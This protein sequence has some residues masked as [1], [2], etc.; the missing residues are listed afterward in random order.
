[1]T[2]FVLRYY[3]LLLIFLLASPDKIIAQSPSAEV[4]KSLFPYPEQGIWLLHFTGFNQYGEP[5]QLSLAHDQKNVH[6]LLQNFNTHQ[7]WKIEGLWQMSAMNTIVAD[8]S[9][10]RLGQMK[11]FLRDS[12]LTADIIMDHDQMASSFKLKQTAMYSN[13]FPPC[14]LSIV[15][16]EYKTVSGKISLGMRVYEDGAIT[17][18][19]SNLM[20]STASWF[21]GTC[22]SAECKSALVIFRDCNSVKKYK[23]KMI[24]SD[25]NRV[26]LQ[27]ISGGKFGDVILSL[28]RVLHFNC[29]NEIQMGLQSTS[30]YPLIEERNF[31]KWLVEYNRKWNEQIYLYALK[32]LLIN[33]TFTL[34]W[35][36]SWYSDQIL[37]GSIIKYEPGSMTPIEESWNYDIKADEVFN[38]EDL[39]EK[40]SN[41]RSFLDHYLYEVKVNM[42][43][44]LQKELYEFI[45]SDPFRNYNLLPVGIVFSTG[46]NPVFG[47]YKILVP[48]HVLLD[49]LKKNGPLK[50]LL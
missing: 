11:S 29:K 37:S 28:E 20:D 23:A 4:L 38:L 18:F 31:R 34:E 40:N 15:Y 45:V 30:R 35:I 12:V 5:L 41:Y 10:N 2:D 24:M 9:G 48:Y 27:N 25:S 46:W 19:V 21:S 26:E 1:M 7:R 36:P 22:Q 43:D 33:Q 14:P 3:L 17:G 6:G 32:S 16:K 39:F 44:P 49:K 8:S 13:E 42:C 50:R 47:E